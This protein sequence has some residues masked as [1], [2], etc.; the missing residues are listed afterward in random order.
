MH[1]AE[2][3]FQLTTLLRNRRTVLTAKQMSEHLRVSERT[4]YR[5]IQSLSLS[6]VPIEGEAGVGYRLSHRYQLPPLMFD[7]EEVEALLLGARM[8]SSWGDTDMAIH[9][10]QAIQKILSVLPDHLRHSDESLPLLVPNMEEVQKYYTAHSQPMR[11]AIRLRQRV[12]IDYVRADEQHSSRT[13]EPLGMIFWGKVW[14]LVAWCH[15]RDD[16]RT[17]RL[18]RIQ[19]IVVTDEKFDTSESKSLKHFL[20][21]M[22]EKYAQEPEATAPHDC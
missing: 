4:I 3:L 21:L 9:A 1:R 12:A 15:L 14:T 5:D 8:V 16:Y 20:H 17:F 19:S 22:K 13:I 10:N 6:G 7:R 11:E 18:D 2:R